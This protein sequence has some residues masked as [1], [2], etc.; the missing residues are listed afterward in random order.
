MDLS[1]EEARKNLAL[2]SVT[3]ALRSHHNSAVSIS[4]PLS[5]TLT[6]TGPTGTTAQH[7]HI[8][9]PLIPRRTLDEPLGSVSAQ[10]TP[11]DAHGVPLHLSPSQL[12]HEMTLIPGDSGQKGGVPAAPAGQPLSH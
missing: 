6:P 4:E 12:Y 8:S 2:R 5:E 11:D 3:L 1:R 7:R 10:L 9:D